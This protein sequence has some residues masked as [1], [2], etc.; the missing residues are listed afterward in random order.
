[1][2]TFANLYLYL[3]SLVGSILLG[4]WLTMKGVC[5][6]YGWRFNRLVAKGGVEM[7]EQALEEQGWQKEMDL[8]AERRWREPPGV[9]VHSGAGG[10][11]RAVSR[12]SG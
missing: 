7:L 5:L 1:M 4:K 11:V 9:R 2:S 10:A 3:T 6:W 12:C 8:P